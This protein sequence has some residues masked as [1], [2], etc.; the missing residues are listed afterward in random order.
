MRLIVVLLLAAALVGCGGSPPRERSL[1]LTVTADGYNVTRLDAVAG[2]IVFVRFRNQDAIAHS[3][4]VVLPNGQRT[5]S[6]EDGVD[7]VISFPVA[8]AGSF[9]FFCPVAGHTEAGELV[10]AP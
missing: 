5:V 4:T 8:Q 9:R 10:V 2:E 1:E 6:A 7:A 3:M